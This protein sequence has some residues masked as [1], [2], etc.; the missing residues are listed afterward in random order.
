MNE[1]K[2]IGGIVV[3]VSVCIAVVVIMYVIYRMYFFDEE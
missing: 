1:V 2:D 3:F